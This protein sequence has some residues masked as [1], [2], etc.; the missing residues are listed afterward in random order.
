MSIPDL[1]IEYNARLTVLDH[2]E[3]STRWDAAAAQYRDEADAE[4]DIAYGDTKRSCYDFFPAKNTGPN[5]PLSVFIHGGYWRARS[6]KTDSHIA[7]NLNARGISV[8]IPSYDLV[9]NV[10]IMEIV[11]Q[12]RGFLVHLWKKTGVRPVVAGNSAGGHL[13]GAMLATNWVKIDGVPDDLV[14]HAFALSGLYDLEPLLDTDVNDD[15]RLTPESARSTSP[16]HW[17][18]PREGLKY[19]AAVGSLES[20]VFKVQSR[21][22]TDAWNANGIETEYFEVPDCNHFTIV[23]AFSTPG[24]ALSERFY[25]MIEAHTQS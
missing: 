22:L 5:T 17:P 6:G 16:I 21:R 19:V 25:K 24:H 20:D 7:K 8:A 23:D 9:P 12:M 10:T 18:A 2:A 4:L 14:T 13:T 15:L 1:N 11:E 3:I